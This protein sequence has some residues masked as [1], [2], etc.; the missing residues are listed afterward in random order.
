[1][2]IGDIKIHEFKVGGLDLTDPS[3]ALPNEINICEDIL[4]SYGPVCDV[5]VTDPTDAVSK[6]K[7]NSGYNQ[8]VSIRFSD[9]NGKVCSF[10]FKQLE[11]ND[12]HDE[13]QNLQGS[14]RSKSYTL[15]FVSPEL[16]NAQG[17]YVEKSWSDKTTNI[18][19]D[20]IKD[21]YKSDKEIFIGDQSREKRTWIAS[22]KHPLEVLQNLND[23]HVAT[24]SKSS[25]YC[26]YQEQ[27][28]GKQK[29]CI[30]TFE[31]L[32]K[33]TS[34]ATYNVSTVLDS[35]S[36]T[37]NDKKYS[38]ISMNVGEN[39]S[40]APRHNT[41]ASE[42][43]INLT[44][45]GVIQTDE[46]DENY[47]VLGQRVFQGKTPNHKL[48]PQSKVYSKV[49]EKEKVTP[50]DAKRKRAQ[51]LAQ[52]AQNSCEIEIP[53]NPDVHLGS[54]IT[55]NLPK[56]EGAGSGGFESQFNG[57][58]LVV[59]LRHV[60]QPAGNPEMGKPRYRMI[61]RCVKAGWEQGGGAA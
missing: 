4:N 8:D 40:S 1:M 23:E 43:T 15:K 50:A 56:R 35:S 59:A 32:M 61:A 36:S 9:E 42:Q 31:N 55:L 2:A 60:I 58:V 25:A 28:S 26:I 3:Q 30:D 24:Q 13:S 11:N 16:L 52:L 5:R 12:L 39:S 18:A 6:N 19:R 14:L 57:K 41:H 22:N 53:G 29:Y 34:V 7:I 21:N 10:K 44:T 20:V 46:K 17:N 37:E 54:V 27:K 49:N 48:V 45:H 51:F 47:T 33:K 38:I